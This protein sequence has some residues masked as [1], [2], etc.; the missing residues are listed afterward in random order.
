[1]NRTHPQTEDDHGGQ[2][3]LPREHGH[4]S[5]VFHSSLCKPN[6]TLAATPMD[7]CAKGRR[8]RWR[9]SWA[10][11]CLSFITLLD[12]VPPSLE[13]QWLGERAF[14]ELSPAQ[15]QHLVESPDSAK[16]LDTSDP[17]S[18]LSRILIP[19]VGELVQLFYYVV[20]TGTL[21][22]QPTPKTTQ[23]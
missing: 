16:N 18:H 7:A 17:S 5:D 9:H 21:P 22:R 15:I 14:R 13:A 3:Q 2:K 6:A 20:G 1:M 11:L 4:L 19:R 8:R 10:T 12:L 23:W